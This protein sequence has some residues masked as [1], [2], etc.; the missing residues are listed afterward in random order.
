MENKKAPGGAAQAQSESVSMITEKP[1]DVKMLQIPIDVMH[2]MITLSGRINE[3]NREYGLIGVD[4]FG[5]R[6]H[7]DDDVFNHTF[8]L[9]TK[10][11]REGEYPICREAS[12]DGVRFFC[13]MR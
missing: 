13:L 9:Y 4:A 8:S 3:L 5:R 12:V 7:L 10:T 6:I 1:E 2:E 11:R